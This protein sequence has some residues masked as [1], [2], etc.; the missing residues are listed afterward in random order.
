MINEERRK[1]IISRLNKIEG[2][3]SG[4][5][6]MVESERPCIEILTQISS[7]HEA[8][9][10]VGK[11]IMRNYLETCVT[12]AIRSKDPQKADETYKNL[13]DVIYKFAK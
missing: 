13:M 5:R 12:E 2:Q 6:K 3:L 4:I 7:I 11:V 9:R 8:L 10:G 1:E